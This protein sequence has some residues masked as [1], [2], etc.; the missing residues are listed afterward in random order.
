MKN[1]NE[2]V[3][4]MKSLMG[5]SESKVLKENEE[6]TETN[7]GDNV[8]VAKNGVKVIVSEWVKSHI[9][10]N[11]TKVGK[12]SIFLKDWMPIIID[13]IISRLFIIRIIYECK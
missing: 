10:D 7:S 12:G 2:Q 8:V 1:L 9:D 3:N 11:H 6:F 13:V 4:R 5:I